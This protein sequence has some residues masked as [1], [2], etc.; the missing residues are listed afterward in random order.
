MRINLLFKGLAVLLLLGA[1]Q[2]SVLA[3]P[4]CKGQSKNDP[5]CNQEVAAAAAVVD[6]VTVDWFNQALV[7]RGSGFT[8]STSFLLGSSAT[9]LATANVT[10]TQLDI[11]FAQVGGEL[12]A[13]VTLQGNY[14]LEV[15]GSVQLSVYIESQIIDPA[16][17]GCPCEAEWMAAPEVMWS[18]PTPT[19]SADCY[20]I[21][22]L[23]PNDVADISGTIHS[24]YS[25]NTIYPQYPIGASYYPGDP[26][27]AVCMLVQVNDDAS[28]VNLVSHRIN[29]IQQAECAAALAFYVCATLTP[30]P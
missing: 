17:T 9:P 5:G 6:S 22:G 28:V 18:T 27:S 16:A 10:D 14:N 19:P 24:D 15:D 3:A 21:T 29:E 26:E 30:L 25:V 23:D 1:F 8:G 11:P 2:A 13:E 12:A 7:V 4:A 20:E